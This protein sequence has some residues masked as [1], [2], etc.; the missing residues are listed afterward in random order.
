MPTEDIK[1][2]VEFNARKMASDMAIWYHVNDIGA[3]LDVNNLP[4]TK[5]SKNTPKHSDEIWAELMTNAIQSFNQGLEE[6]VEPEGRRASREAYEA[7]IDM[8]G[9]EAF[10]TIAY[11][12][13]AA[14]VKLAADRPSELIGAA[15]SLFME[16]QN[17][18]QDPGAMEK[19]KTDTSTGY[20]RIWQIQQELETMS[21]DYAGAGQ[22][23]GSLAA[24]AQ[25]LLNSLTAYSPQTGA[26]GG[27]GMTGLPTGVQVQGNRQ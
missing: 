2:P 26:G 5:E 20:S 1:K 3:T 9:D 15:S 4:F 18:S 12:V 23:I 25:E 7:A 21:K 6:Y 10:S 14:G 16:A 13:S 24:Q 22:Q 27:T 8:V 17:L 11:I 19:G